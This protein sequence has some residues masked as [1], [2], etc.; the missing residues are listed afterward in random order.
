MSDQTNV[1][2]KTGD[3]RWSLILN[4]IDAT[5]FRSDCLG[6]RWIKTGWILLKQ[7]NVWP[8]VQPMSEPCEFVFVPR[9]LAVRDSVTQIGNNTSKSEASIQ[10][11]TALSAGG[12]E[13]SLTD[14][15][16]AVQPREHKTYARLCGYGNKF[17]TKMSV[18]RRKRSARRLQTMRR[19]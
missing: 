10:S 12:M 2:R 16:E 8:V 6:Q 14:R 4:Q 5:R 15:L 9:K 13:N 7:R 17:E 18:S 1:I 3:G 11:V 19:T